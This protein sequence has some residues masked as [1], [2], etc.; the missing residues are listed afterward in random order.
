MG[1][2]WCD[3]ENMVQRGV[4]K[5]PYTWQAGE[6]ASFYLTQLRDEKKLWGKRC[7]KCEKVLAPPRKNCPF[8]TVLTD[9]WVELSGE[10][11][12]DT[13][14]VVHKATNIHPMKPPFAY[15]VIKLDGADTGF[16][17]VLGEV[18]V[19][20]VKEGLR[21]RAVFAEDRVGLPT[22]IAYFKPAD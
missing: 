14:T 5:L 8:C 12:V 3:A 2:Y 9:K 22:D 11:T 15:A 16:L 13:Y 21:V 4:I 20:R 17:H 6:T 10:G 7:P 1:D 19:D 18:E